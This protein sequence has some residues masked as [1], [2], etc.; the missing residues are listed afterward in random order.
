MRTGRTGVT[1]MLSNGQTREEIRCF[2]VS[3]C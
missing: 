3:G 1:V 2:E